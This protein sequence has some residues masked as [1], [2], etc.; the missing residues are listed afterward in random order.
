[1]RIGRIK[2]LVF[3]LLLAGPMLACQSMNK[4]ATWVKSKVPGI[5]DIPRIADISG[6][7]KIVQPVL[8]PTLSTQESMDL[9]F[10][11]NHFGEKRYGDAE[12]YLKKILVEI[13]EHPE[14]MKLLPWVHFYQKHYAKAQNSFERISGLDPQASGCL[15]RPGL[16]PVCPAKI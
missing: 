9:Q 16:E 4:A 6:I 15:D 12:Y 10:A 2:I 7:A 13:P 3:L 14:A 1:M 11:R 5:D 8:M